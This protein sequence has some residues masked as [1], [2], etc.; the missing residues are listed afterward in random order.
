[1]QL[2]LKYFKMQLSQANAASSLQ[3]N[4]QMLQ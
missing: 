1:M 2:P 4:Q 3:S